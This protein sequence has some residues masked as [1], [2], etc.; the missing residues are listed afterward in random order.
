MT[1]VTLLA[2]FI[3]GLNQLARSVF[4]IRPEDSVPLKIAKPAAMSAMLSSASVFI[5]LPFSN[6]KT[7]IIT[8]KV[9]SSPEAAR[10]I[11]YAIPR[12]AEVATFRSGIL[13]MYAG[14]WAELI[15]QNWRQIFRGPCVALLPRYY[16]ETLPK[17]YH[18]IVPI[19][20]GSSTAIID[21]TF[22]TP[23]EARRQYRNSQALAVGSEVKFR[24]FMGYKETMARQV[25]AWTIMFSTMEQIRIYGYRLYDGKEI[26][27]LYLALASGPFAATF[28]TPTH[29]L[30]MVK[31]HQ[32]QA[33]ASKYGIEKGTSIPRALQLI[34]LYGL[35]NHGSLGGIRELFRGCTASVVQRTPAA[36]IMLG[37]NEFF[38]R[39]RN[40]KTPIK[41]LWESIGNLKTLASKVLENFA[42]SK[43]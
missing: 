15:R 23:F 41:P 9:K 25:C 16:T 4:A 38:A 17:E 18:S 37:T 34:Y 35:N 33:G 27:Y 28:L 29:P 13:N 32:Q 11:F 1:E 19:L 36:F 39:Q 2:Q 12:G 5:D 22:S 30:D 8:S 14:L 20:A 26:S 24:W 10:A 31:V 40:D 43:G 7:A 21:A 6:I 3:S 42:R